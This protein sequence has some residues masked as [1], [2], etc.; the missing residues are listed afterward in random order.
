MS[1]RVLCQV[2]Q[3]P[4]GSGVS[5]CGEH[6]DELVEALRS[7]ATGGR[8]RVRHH[9]VGRR[10]VGGVESTTKRRV[11]DERPGL[12]ADLD[13]TIS[14]QHKLAAPGPANR[15]GETP[16]PFHEGAS[17]AA[18]ELRRVVIRWA[19]AIDAANPHLTL[20]ATSVAG[21]AAWLS[22]LPNLL[23]ED[24]R[25]GV[26]YREVMRAVEQ[27]VRVV[28]REPDRVY[29]GQCGA[30]IG[31]DEESAIVEVCE[32]DIYAPADTDVM[33]CRWC[34]AIW[35][36]SARRDYLLVHVEDQLAT[37]NEASRALS[38][39]GRPVAAA[40]IRSWVHREKLM[41]YAPRSS[42]RRRQPLYRIGDVLE[43]LAAAAEDTASHERVVCARPAATPILVIVGEVS[44]LDR[45]T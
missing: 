35:E 29:L 13:L 37:A 41:Q 14:R 11:V 8:V 16:V 34:G 2:C 26:M 30:E 4:L 17:D 38:R 7:L 40:T 32:G 44:G 28:D 5:L 10:R 3:R 27:A 1:D 36:V 18:A 42:D 20:T 22:R 45:P 21:A 9:V 25:A 19:R 33:Q 15:S 39:L 12:C 23:A 24:P 6:R 31:Y 43:L